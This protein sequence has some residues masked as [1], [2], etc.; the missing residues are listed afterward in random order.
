MKFL[1]NMNLPRELGKLLSTRGHAFR[2]IGDIG[3]ARA[4][5]TA[6]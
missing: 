2:H 5:D 3:M 6:I 4:S 1:L